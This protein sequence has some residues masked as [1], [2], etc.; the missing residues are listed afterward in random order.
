MNAIAATKTAKTFKRKTSNPKIEGLK[1]Q[2]ADLLGN[3][4]AEVNGRILGPLMRELRTEM[5]PE[6]FCADTI[7]HLIDRFY[8]ETAQDNFNIPDFIDRL[9][10]AFSAMRGAVGAEQKGEMKD[11]LVQL[12][13]DLREHELKRIDDEVNSR[14][15][16]MGYTASRLRMPLAFAALEEARYC[17]MYGNGPIDWDAMQAVNQ[18]MLA[19]VVVNL[20]RPRVSDSIRPMAN[21]LAYDLISSVSSSRDN[22]YDWANQGLAQ[23]LRALASHDMTRKDFIA[24]H[25]PKVQA[26]LVPAK[27]AK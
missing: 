25:A 26:A 18:D 5:G 7:R 24:Q 13:A 23:D 4:D 3:K 20:Q 22:P 17:V 10:S 2:I 14:T 6:N 27:L 12:A 8:I 11:A 1:A 19:T 16:G 21:S 15:F 9:E